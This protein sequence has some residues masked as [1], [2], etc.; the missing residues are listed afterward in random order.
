MARMIGNT[1]VHQQCRYGCCGNRM[2]KPKATR[3]ETEL[4]QK[5]FYEEVSDYPHENVLCT[6]KSGMLGCPMCYP[7]DY[8]ANGAEDLDDIEGVT[9]NMQRI[10]DFE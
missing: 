10:I 2:S 1:R 8:D 3:L 5:D 9:T 7:D 4:W 6:D